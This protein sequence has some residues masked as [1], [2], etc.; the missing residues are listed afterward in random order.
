VTFT[1]IAPTET[2]R[3]DEDGRPHV[4]VYE[5]KLMHQFDHRFA[6]YWDGSIL[7]DECRDLRPSD[8]APDVLVVP[9]SWG[10]EQELGRRLSNLGWDRRYLLGY[11]DVARASDERTAIAAILPRV[12]TDNTIRLLVTTDEPAVRCC[13][14]NAIFN[15]FAFDFAARNVVPSTHFS[16]YLA[17][18]LPVPLPEVFGRGCR[19]L[20]GSHALKDWVLQRVLELTF[21]AWDLEAFAQ[22]CG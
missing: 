13:L 10:S 1:D 18:Q 3:C 6:T 14:L 9:R 17:K 19:W 21:T 22:D 8:R 5:A 15:S 20:R 11:R 12:I 16:E 4:R 7:S 2:S